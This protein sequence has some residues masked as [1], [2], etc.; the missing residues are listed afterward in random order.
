MV[1]RGYAHLVGVFRVGNQKHSRFQDTAG[2]GRAGIKTDIR[3]RISRGDENVE[4]LI[5]A[6]SVEKIALTTG[7]LSEKERAILTAGCMIN[8]SRGGK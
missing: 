2:H 4:A 1:I 8:Y 7:E 3:S 5:L 6:E